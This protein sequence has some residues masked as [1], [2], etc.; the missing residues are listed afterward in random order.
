MYVN[1][2]RA[3]ARKVL[4]GMLLLFAGNVQA[5]SSVT[6]FEEYD[7][8]I[9]N[10]T[11]VGTL[12]N[13]LFGDQ[14][15]LYSGALEFTQT[16]VSLPGN[17]ALP[18]SIGRRFTPVQD[19]FQAGHFGDWQLEIPHLHGVFDSNRPWTVPV[20]PGNPATDAY[21][22]CTHFGAPPSSTGTSGGG[23]FAP[24]E[25]WQG[26]FFYLPGAGDQEILRKGLVEV[27]TDGNAYAL[28]TKSGAAVRCL[29]ELT[30]HSMAAGEGFEVVTPDGIRYRF[31]HLV[32]RYS[33]ALSKGSP[34]PEA[35]A[36][37][38]Y[39]LRR[40]EVWIL[41][42]TITDR[43]GNTVTYTY[44]AT[45]P[46]QLTQIAASDGRQ[47]TIGY[48]AGTS[49]IASVSDGSQTWTYAYGT[50]GGA[51]VPPLTSVTLPDNSAW[52]FQLDP[53]RLLTPYVEG[54]SCG[55]A[56][57]ANYGDQTGTLSHPGGAT[58]S[59]TIAPVEFGRSWVPLDCP[60]GLE[61]AD[62]IPARSLSAA[63]KKKT[64]S[65]PGLP[66]AGESWTYAYGPTNACNLA[67]GPWN[68]AGPC[69]ANSPVTRTVNV[70]SPEGDLTRYTFGNRYE[71]NE[72]QLLRVE[73]GW[74]G[75]AAL[76]T[77][78]YTYAAPS[79]GP[80]PDPVG[81]SAQM[82]GD[83]YLSTRH[84]PQQ[85]QV[86]T[87]QGATFGR[88]VESFDEWAKPLRVTRSSSLGASRTEVTAYHHNKAKWVLGQLASV[89]CI[90]TG[91]PCGSGRVVSSAIYDPDT[92]QPT[93]ITSFGRPVQT[94]TYDTTSAPA[95]GQRGTVKTVADGNN[96]STTLTQWYRGIPRHIAY[97]DGAVQT[98]QVNPQGWVTSVTDEV[99]AVTGY[100]YDVM[101]RLNRITWPAGDTVAWQQ[102][103]QVFEPVAVAEYGLPAG[104][105][106]QTVSTGD[107]RKVTY[108][109]ALWRPRV[110]RE[111][112]A[113]DVAGTQ[114][115]TRV[116][117][118]GEG[119]TVFASYPGA[120]DALSTG[121]WNE[122]DAL[123]RVTSVSQDSELGAALVTTTQ[124]L[125]GFL[126]QV[127]NPRNQ[128]TVTGYLAFDTP[129][130]DWPVSISHPEGAYTDIVRDVFGK[131]RSITRRNAAGTTGLTRGY[132]YDGYQQLCRSVEPETG[133]TLMGYDGAGNLAWSAAGL[134]TGTACE[135]SGN[136]S[137]V[138]ARKTVRTYD[139]RNRVKTLS[140][141]DG[142]GDTTYA[143]ENDGAL[144]QLAVDN[145][146]NEV[147]TTTY[148]YNKRRL[149]VSE[150]VQFGGNDWSIGYGYSVAGH[151]AA[152]TVPGLTVTYAPNALGQ[153]TQAG[154]YATGV[155]YYPNGAVRQFT[156]GNGIVHTM[157]QNA[158]QLPARSTDSGG[159]NPLDLAYN[160]DANANV[161]AI[162]D[163]AAGGTQSRGMVYDGL[164][165]LV[166]AT[167]SS[168]GTASYA[169]NVLDDITE[170]KISAAGTR[171]RDHLYDY[172]PATHQLSGIRNRA[173]GATVVGLHYDVQGNLDNKN[174]RLHAFDFGNRL[175][176]VAAAG[177]QAASSYA[178]DGHGRRVRDTTVGDKFSLYSQSGQLVY[179]HDRRKAKVTQYV[180][181]AGSLVARVSNSIAPVA[182]GL[183]VPSFSSTGSYT[184]SWQ[185]SSQATGYELEERTG[186]GAW[187]PLYTGTATS[188]A[189][190]GKV[191]GTYSY[192][193]RACLNQGCGSWSAEATVAVQ[194]APTATAALSVPVTAVGGTY[195]VSWTAVGGAESYTLKE[196]INSGTWTT[197]YTGTAQSQGYTGKAAGSY[198][199][200]VQGCNQAGCGPLSNIGTVSAVHAPT[201]APA[202]SVPATSTTGSYTVSWTAV[203]TATT[204][205]VEQ[206]A[207]GG[208]WTSVHNAAGTSVALSGRATG[209]YSYRARA[210]NEA[211]CGGYSTSATVQVTL[212]P[213][214]APA[215]TIPATNGTGSYTVSWTGVT[216]ATGYQLEENLD[217]GAWTAIYNGAATSLARSGRGNGTHGYRVRA[218]NGSGC[219]PDSA[220][221]T[222]VVALPPPPVPTG[223]YVTYNPDTSP[224]AMNFSWNASAGATTYQLSGGS[225]SYSGS[226]T[227]YQSALNNP[228]QSQYSVRAC[229]V[230]GC[231]A[232]STS[233]KALPM[234]LRK[235]P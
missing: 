58:G 169:Y 120:T 167:G 46:W 45:D 219:G 71:V 217:G 100:G 61:G 124:Y 44:D 126:T 101:G 170:L 211:G 84:T 99:N 105:W 171:T 208:A 89:T 41:P 227:T 116:A 177:G 21:L 25:F 94:L 3:P 90:A 230:N 66:A 1:A 9:Q 144:Q 182:S 98:A 23:S 69:N 14:I 154:T 140:F 195:T 22:R 43:H 157:T 216:G 186:A 127:T 191:A 15:S 79:A 106:R 82:R 65:G 198:R 222:V 128:S 4:A 175:R 18:V 92:A 52:T 81:I 72:G 29:A 37:V 115:F 143:Y 8:L 73:A 122:Y 135:A 70:T 164:D 96:N 199:Y 20:N 225:I 166:Q 56:G 97:A 192:R 184:V 142:K 117:Y 209:S 47:L 119:R 205:Q 76:S 134:A 31:D 133:A 223:L 207:G 63:L 200:Q 91:E 188:Q 77:T 78:D 137:A 51:V 215:L 6:A 163:Y 112:D 221:A 161:S 80:Y 103:T 156:Y 87:Q 32:T 152:Q 172:D 38:S 24:Q 85:S 86:I 102:T 226:A 138:L 150:R 212:P 231:S 180:H 107:A 83:G 168:F 228:T 53:I 110:V 62:H 224:K 118:D 26:N 33:P 174:G 131:P 48:V 27:P 59:F 125:S 16:D 50:P 7:K 159:G 193:L 75:S 173:G 210:C 12:G 233:V 214:S 129:S 190:S 74:N 136:S 111:Y 185:P 30:S 197:V 40:K 109:D 204:Y 64:L 178:Y 235:A 149:P 155:Q 194:F 113:A 151:L 19:R 189:I 187:Q 108:F 42:T 162:T 67:G 158:R 57:V 213:A 10:R 88:L 146:N 35:R 60:D 176:N 95:S 201:A 234:L 165:R 49:R 148:G 206:S 104:H 34:A 130:Q 232:W 179:E 196:S 202:V 181:L 220:T 36:P 11:A 147:V 141:P 28:V 145:G 203:A 160:Y 13:D 17:D 93:Q 183:T 114:R 132:D 5:Q 229:N 55:V 139:A 123:G 54:G 153:A 121:T 218:C 2:G 39:L 68:V